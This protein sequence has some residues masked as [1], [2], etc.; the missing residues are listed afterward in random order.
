MRR[1]GAGFGA[2]VAAHPR[3][4]LVEFVSAN[5][6]G[7]LTVASGRHA[8]YGDSLARLLEFA[9]ERV[10]REYYLN[11]AGGQIRP[12][13]RSRSRARMTGGE[14]P[15]GGYEGDYVDRAAERLAGGGARAR[16]RGC[17]R[18]AAAS[19]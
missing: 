18:H 7:P 9:G 17:A 11:D 13:R 1:L 16:R 10:E 19:S 12:L 6:T 8:A 2:G 15:E 14:V 3:S 4:V 5:P